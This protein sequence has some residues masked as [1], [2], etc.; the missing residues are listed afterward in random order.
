MKKYL[1]LMLAF[2]VAFNASGLPGVQK[3]GWTTTTNQTEARN[4]LAAAGTNSPAFSG[5]LSIIN[6]NGE[7]G[8]E[9]FGDA[10]NSNTARISAP[11]AIVTNF[12]WILPD[13][14][15]TG[16]F[17]GTV[18]GV[19][20]VTLTQITNGSDGQVLKMS[21]STVAWGTDAGNTSTN[22][23]M[24]RVTNLISAGTIAVTGAVTAA[25]ASFSGGTSNVLGGIN[26]IATNA[27]P[28]SVTTNEFV[29]NTLY[30]NSN[31]R[32]W[33]SA[34][35]QLSAAVAGT[36]KVTLVTEGTYTN[37]LSI[38]AG[39]LASL[40]TVE[41]LLLPV[42]PN[43]RFYFTNETSGSGGTVAVVD[44]TSSLIGE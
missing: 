31:R 37:R 16:L 43:F 44:G 14:P 42:S 27:A 4:A 8:S 30:T 6:T 36:A 34:S 28:F 7:S 21:G 29:L 22:F 12:N 20:N 40:V 10:D 32:A 2:F 13:R 15:L 39:P 5:T 25:T 19:S 26:F 3:S 41:P 1:F 35:F 33:V 23:E 38:S 18:S 17:Y 24:L 9:T 11:T